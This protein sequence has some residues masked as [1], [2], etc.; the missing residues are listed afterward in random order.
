VVRPKQAKNHAKRPAARAI[1]FA[2]HGIHT[3]KMNWKPRFPCH[4]GTAAYRAA[5]SA[6]TRLATLETC[7]AGLFLLDGVSQW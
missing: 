1:I 7:Y 3:A 6:D 4:G 2:A 5:R